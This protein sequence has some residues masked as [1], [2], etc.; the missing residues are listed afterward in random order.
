MKIY[1]AGPMSGHEDWNFP[2][3]FEAE[4]QLKELGYETL[5]PATNDGANLETAIQ[6]AISARD[7]GAT[8][9]G[10]M[11]RDLHSLSLSDAVC[12]LPDWKSSK[13]ASLEV[14]VAQAL[15]I[16][17][18]ILKDGVLTPRVT[19]IGIA[20]WARSGKDTV[21]NYLVENEG[22][23]K[24]SFSTP[25]KEAMY[26][27]NPR[28]TINEIVNQPLRIGVDVYGWEGLKER[29]PDIRGLLQRF[30]TEVG[31]NMFSE[32][33]WV[34]Y[35][36]NSVVDGTKVVIADVRYPNEADAIKALG[37]KVY[38]VDRDGVGPANEHASENAL[39]G[40]EFDGTIHN[41]GNLEGLY[42]NVETHILR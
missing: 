41:Q 6:N 23:T 10:Y 20:G 13:G 27:L 3:F 40:Y 30:G 31:R 11:R 24:I 4:E 19:V 18:Y 32:N 9:A 36:L 33:F 15:G 12:V 39:E 35:A 34:D 42:Y 14:Q 7:S 29:S 22:Y 25:M 16:P 21:A 8:W 5:N 17:I 38:R 26:R 2:A 1:I 28:I 37:G